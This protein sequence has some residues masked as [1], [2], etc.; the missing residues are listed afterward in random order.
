MAS[1]GRRRAFADFLGRTASL[2][3]PF[4]FDF[5]ERVA[6]DCRDHSGILE[7]LTRL[8]VEILIASGLL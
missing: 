3:S 7:R 4:D 8:D 6:L 2:V 1:S 5:A